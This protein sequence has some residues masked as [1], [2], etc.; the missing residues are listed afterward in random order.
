MLNSDEQPSSQQASKSPSGISNA[1]SSSS[2]LQPL[3]SATMK[4]FK[5]R[6]SSA[7]T[8]EPLTKTT[9]RHIPANWI[10]EQEEGTT[11]LS[12]LSPTQPPSHPHHHDQYRAACLAAAMRRSLSLSSLTSPSESA[13]SSS[14]SND[15]ALT[16]ESS[17]PSSH[18][19]ATHRSSAGSAG[20]GPRVR[21]P[22]Q[23]DSFA[24]WPNSAYENMIDLEIKRRA[25]EHIIQAPSIDL[26]AI[27]VPKPPLLLRQHSDS[28]SIISL[29][30]T[31]SQTSLDD[32]LE[33]DDYASP[34]CSSAEPSPVP[35]PMTATF[36]QQ[37]DSSFPQFSNPFAKSPGLGGSF[38]N[39]LA[40][41]APLSPIRSTYE[42][43]GDRTPTSAPPSSLLR[44]RSLARA[45][46]TELR[47]SFQD[48]FLLDLGDQA[49]PLNL[50]PSPS[51]EHCDPFLAGNIVVAPGTR[52]RS[53]GGALWI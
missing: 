19:G 21:R 15:S 7:K 29:P 43:R 30:R 49:I 37:R 20:H 35:T 24:G 50:V 6:R 2:H 45:R 31:V 5:R 41:P 34:S 13:R 46:E 8:I 12:D 25:S 44:A 33:E 16:S 47:R 9:E 14:S 17:A 22:S 27:A 23:R 3:A 48:N 40:P 53:A 11:K 42:N 32:L 38:G 36:A 39:R 26:Q 51:V 1:N 10:Y 52:R 18:H 4:L 28:Q